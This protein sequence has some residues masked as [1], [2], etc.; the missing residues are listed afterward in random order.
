MRGQKP[1]AYLSPT[2]LALLQQL[3]H[4]SDEQIKALKLEP[5]RAGS[6]IGACATALRLKLTGFAPRADASAQ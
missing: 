2:Q 5:V 1:E 3:K 4:L 6:A